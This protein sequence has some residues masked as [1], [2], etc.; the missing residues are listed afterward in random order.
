[1]HWFVKD[2]AKYS[3]GWSLMSQLT[4]YKLRIAPKPLRWHKCTL[5]WTWFCWTTI[6]PT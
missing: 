4:Y 3:K 1:M 5:I 2:F 6:S